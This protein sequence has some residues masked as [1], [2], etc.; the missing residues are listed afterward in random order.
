MDDNYQD[1]VNRVVQMTLPTAYR[2]QLEFIQ[3]SPKFI[4]HADG[5]VD[6][7]YFPGYSIVTPPGR[8]DSQNREMYEKMQE[9]QQKIKQVFEQ[10]GYDNFIVPVT[11]DSF[12]FTVADLIWHTAF[13]DAN[14]DPE[15]E[16]KLRS[17]IGEILRDCQDLEPQIAQMR[18]QVIGIML[19]TRAIGVCLAPSDAETYKKTLEIRRKVYQNSDLMALGIEQQYHFT[20][21]L[22]LGYFGKIPADLDRDKLAESL[23]ELNQQWLDTQ[24]DFS[25]ERIELRKFEDMMNYHR[26][27][28]WPFLQLRG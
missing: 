12:H 24:N 20:G 19:R 3:Q 22:T 11:I 27:P 13:L 26:Q 7:A 17:L 5:K 9:Y 25:F 4:H 1:Y 2:A 28:D 14:Q 8:E 23:N 21:H 6:T 18:W 10:A 15:F 16:T